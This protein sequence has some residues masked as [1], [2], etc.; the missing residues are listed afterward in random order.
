[1]ALEEDAGR[2]AG[3]EVVVVLGGNDRP[4]SLERLLGVLGELDAARLLPLGREIVGV[5]DLR[6]VERGRHARERAPGARVARRELD[7]LAGEV[8]RRHLE[9][10][11]VAL[12]HE[13]A[14]LRSDQKLSHCSP[15]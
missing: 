10:P 1:M 5:E 12:E 6:P 7:R 11:A 2:A 13:Q 4:E 3:V 8:P 9:C 15:S 14:L